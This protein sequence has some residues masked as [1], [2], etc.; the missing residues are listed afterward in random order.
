[1]I[2][3]TQPVRIG[4]EIEVGGA[5]GRVEEVGLTYTWLRMRDNDRLV[6]PNEKLTSDTIRNS[7]IR[8]R[9]SIAEVTV[10]LP[11]DADVRE[12]VDALA[13][14]SA[15]VYVTRLGD[16]VTVAVRRWVDSGVAVDKVESDL[17]LDVH[18]R[19]RM[20]GVFA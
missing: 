10:Q 19:L 13:S 15:E 2:A 3:F 14:D 18:E 17:R 7:T 5:R 12:V 9:D 20:L 6:I 11:L 8:S 1:M 4:D 16:R